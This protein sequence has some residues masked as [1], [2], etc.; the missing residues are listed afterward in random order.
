MEEKILNMLEEIC[1]DEEIRNDYD[2]DLFDADLL[3]SLGFAELLVTIEEEFGI[4]ISPSEVER[5]DM[6]T[7]NKII[8]MIASRS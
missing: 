6:N 2:L 1:E 4:V 5:T 8:T 3:D 7:V